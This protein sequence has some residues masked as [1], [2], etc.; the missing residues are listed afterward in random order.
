VGLNIPDQWKKSEF[1]CVLESNPHLII[2]RN[3]FRNNQFHNSNIFLI[4]KFFRKF[5]IFQAKDIMQEKK[6]SY[7]IVYNT[8]RF[9][10]LL[11]TFLMISRSFSGVA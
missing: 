1:N 9:P 11:K 4:L 10:V 5:Y 8:D 2:L 6:Y 3:L 7:L